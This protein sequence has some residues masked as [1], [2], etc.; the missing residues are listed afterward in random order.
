MPPAFD[1]GVLI[2]N[3]N[4]SVGKVEPLIGFDTAFVD[5]RPDFGQTASADVRLVGK[6]AAQAAPKVTS[7]GGDMVTVAA[8]AAQVGRAQ[9]LR[10]SCRGDRVGMHAGRVVVDTGVAEQPT[11]ALSWGCRV[12]ATL[13]VVPSNPYFNLRVS[14]DLAATLVVSSSQTGFRVKS[15]RV[16]EGPFSATLEQARPDGSTSIIIR[17]K[18]DEIADDARAATGK[19]LIQSNDEREPRKEVPLF[20]FGRANKAARPESD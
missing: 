4:Q 2:Q 16:I 17:V 1:C 6:R 20:G 13:Q 7:I 11:L 19:L 9:G 12:P 3:E 18:K 5:L 10:L 15:A 14:G 8:L